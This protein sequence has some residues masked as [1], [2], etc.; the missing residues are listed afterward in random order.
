MLTRLD[1]LPDNAPLRACL[2]E[3]QRFGAHLMAEHGVS[4]A[5]VAVMFAHAAGV[6]LGVDWSRRGRVEDADL[7]ALSGALRGQALEIYGGLAA[8]AGRG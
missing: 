8:A 4:P 5:D 3:A 2:A 7:A 6:A 1:Q